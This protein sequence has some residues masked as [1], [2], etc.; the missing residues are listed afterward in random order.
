MTT[1]V[2]HKRKM[3]E[4]DRKRVP[5][6]KLLH[7]KEIRDAAAAL[8]EYR[9]K[10]N[11]A[12][13]LY[14]A[15]ITLTMDSYGECIAVAKRLET[16]SEFAARLEKARLAEEAK[17]EREARKVIE[18]ELRA[19]NAAERQRKQAIET[20]KNLAQSNGITKD[21]LKALVDSMLT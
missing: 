21:E 10:L 9:L 7:G 15:K 5:L 18:A 12:E 2:Q 4:V 16:D 20:M 1:V 19:A 8:E 13:F 11:E 3:V 14:G 17:K 6:R